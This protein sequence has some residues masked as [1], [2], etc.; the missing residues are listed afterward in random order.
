[1]RLHPKDKRD[2]YAPYIDQFDSVSQGGPIAPW[3]YAA[4]F[5][6]GMT[7]VALVEAA[8]LDRP[9]LS[10]VPRP[11]E[12]QWLPTIAGGITPMVCQRADI[13]SALRALVGA[14]VDQ[15]HVDALIPPG[16]ELRAR[17]AILTLLEA[18]P[19]S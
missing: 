10:I 6:V 19:A 12:S 5:V 14:R 1:M 9:T 18:H 7:S 2:E 17:D 8:L 3:L 15:D 4:D 11:S 16:A 13:P